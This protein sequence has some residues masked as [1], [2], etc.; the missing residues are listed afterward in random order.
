MQVRYLAYLNI[1]CLACRANDAVFKA[2]SGLAKRAFLSV[3]PLDIC[4]A[5]GS[6]LCWVSNPRPWINTEVEGD[7][8]GRHVLDVRPD[9][10]EL[11]DLLL[12]LVLE[13]LEGRVRVEVVADG[14]VEGEVDATNAVD[15]QLAVVRT[16]K[17]EFR[18]AA[19]DF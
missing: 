17:V 2:F 16:K 4:Y 1:Q 19:L 18:Q 6:S 11:G 9:D 8:D 3:T 13:I 12:H 10:V 7:E 14:R 5:L 15:P